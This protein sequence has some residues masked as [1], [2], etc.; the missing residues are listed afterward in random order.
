MMLWLEQS[1]GFLNDLLVVHEERVSTDCAQVQQVFCMY[2]T[3]LHIPRSGKIKLS[4]GAFVCMRGMFLYL[5]LKAF[6]SS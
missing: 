1:L 4:Q 2:S 3:V 5:D 6:S